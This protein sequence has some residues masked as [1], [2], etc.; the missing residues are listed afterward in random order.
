MYP[1][2]AHPFL[3]LLPPFAFGVGAAEYCLFLVHPAYAY[4]ALLAVCIAAWMAQVKYVYSK[5]W[6][7]GGAL[8]LLLAGIGFLRARFDDELRHAAHF[9]RLEQPGQYWTAVLTDAPVP[10]KRL[11]TPVRLLTNSHNLHEQTTVSG[12]AILFIS[13]NDSIDRLR[14]G[15]TLLFQGALRPTKPVSY[16]HLTLPTICRV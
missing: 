9:S 10:G 7:F 16:T 15:D 1:F 13:R 3:R 4:A 12:N 14:Y 11:K 6:L 2:R 8:V 5:R